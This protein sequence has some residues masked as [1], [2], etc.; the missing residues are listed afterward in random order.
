MP[1]DPG[2]SITNG[3]PT[4][5]SGAITTLGITIPPAGTTTTTVQ[6]GP[7]AQGSVTSLPP[8]YTTGQI[9]ALSLTTGGLLRV[10]GSGVTQGVSGTVTVQQFTASNLNV[11]ANQ[12]SPPWTIQRVQNAT[13]TGLTQTRVVAAATTNATSLKASA[14]NIA[15]IDLFNVATY[16]VFLKLYNKISAPTVGTDTPVW[17]IPIPATGGFSIDFSQGEYFS[18]GIAFAITKLQADSDT[19]ALVAGDV[20]GRIKWV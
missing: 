9:N 17:T 11:T 5:G 14:G 16:T 3:V 18:T 15:A 1:V 10:D 4:S 20:T 8:S 6:G 7:M 12:G 19:T 13:A 2:V